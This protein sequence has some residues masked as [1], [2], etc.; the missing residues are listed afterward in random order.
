MSKTIFFVHITAWGLYLVAIIVFSL[1]PAQ[2]PSGV[3][4]QDK[5]LHFCTYALLTIFWPQHFG[6]SF[7]H[8][9]WMASGLGVLL[10]FGQGILPTGRSMEI[11]DMVANTLGAALGLVGRKLWSTRSYKK[12]QL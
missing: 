8:I 4:N 3:E 12:D 7:I 6:P 2:L 1:L 5:V 10:E 9:F 11:G